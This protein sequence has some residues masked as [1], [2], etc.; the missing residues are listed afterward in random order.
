MRL[1]LLTLT[2]TLCIGCFHVAS[3]QAPGPQPLAHPSAAD[4][5]SGA[6]VF[7]T[8]CSR[9]HGLDGTGGMGPPLARPRLRHATDEA[10]IISV[11]VNG[12]PGTAMAPA[13]WL[14]EPQTSQVA[15]YVRSLGTRPE[16]KLPGDPA[17]GREVYARAGC[18]A[19]HIL[20]GEGVGIGPDLS[21][22][23]ALRGSAFLRQSL[24]DPGAARPEKPVPYEPYGYPAFLIVHA[25]PKSGPEV[26]GIRLNEDSFTIQIRDQQGRLQSLRKSDLDRLAAESGTS[27]MPS[28]RDLVNGR[29]L[30]DLVAFLMT[31]TVDR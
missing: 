8:Y 31:R 11:L 15:A 2:L 7:T 9:C 30:E 25:Q 6:K 17:H 22:V 20:K 14:S 12:I 29:D 19:C 24:I 5:A 16:E 13:F 21:D 3:A 26:T 27:L 28:Y 18:A 1:R 10:G 23:G 4:L